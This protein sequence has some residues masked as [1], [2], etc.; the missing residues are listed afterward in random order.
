MHKYICLLALFLTACG[1]TLVVDR[2][3]QNEVILIRA[4]QPDA[5]D[6]AELQ[7]NYGLSTVINLRGAEIIE[8]PNVGWHLEE[9]MFCNQN[10]ITYLCMDLND[11]TLPPS[12][13]DIA[14]Y[15]HIMNQEM[16]HPVLIHCQAGIH[17]TGFFAALYRIQFNGW[18]AE[19]SIEEMES[20][21]FNWSISNRSAIKEYLRSYKHR[22]LD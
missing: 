9:K 19:Q 7:E 4:S 1:P 16:F 18:S 20:H 8:D 5:E 12:E 13:D 22:E 2:N 3:N 21:W 14:L 11:G 15:L 6:L 10:N 17:R